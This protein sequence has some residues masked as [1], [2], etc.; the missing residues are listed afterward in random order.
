MARTC[1]VERRRSPAEPAPEITTVFLEEA[2]VLAHLD[3]DPDPTDL[4]NDPD[5][6]DLWYLDTGATNHMTGVRSV[7]SEPD[8]AVTGFVKF[9]DGSIVTIAGCSTILFTYKN[10][11][12]RRLTGVYFIPRLTA[13]LISIGQLNKNGC[14]SL[15]HDGF[16]RIRDQDRRL[17]AR[18]P[19]S[20]NR[21]RAITRPRCAP[22]VP[23]NPAPQPCLL[24]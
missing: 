18:I 12:H 8:T 1:L 21:H 15:V 5:P 11:E 14:E 16:M 13:N 24:R 23:T 20:R 7:F 22:C 10:C 19:R 17:L 2:K 9:G 6:A 4:D 3:D